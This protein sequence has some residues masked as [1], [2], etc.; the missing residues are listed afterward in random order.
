MFV[1]LILLYGQVAIIKRAL[2][3]F[4]LPKQ[5]AKKF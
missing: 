3:K 2:K 1:R 4:L 5:P